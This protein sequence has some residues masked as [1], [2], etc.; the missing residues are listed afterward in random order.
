MALNSPV[1]RLALLQ[2]FPA[3]R[4][5]Q[6]DENRESRHHL[7]CQHP[8]GR[9]EPHGHRQRGQKH[10]PAARRFRCGPYV[11]CGVDRAVH[12]RSGEPAPMGLVDNASRVRGAIRTEPRLQRLA[13]A[14]LPALAIAGLGPF[15]VRDQCVDADSRLALNGRRVLGRRP[16]TLDPTIDLLRLD[17]DSAGQL[18]LRGRLDLLDRGLD[19]GHAI[20]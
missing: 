11:G 7:D 8:F 1:F 17:L 15:G 5:G 18:S 16:S 20:I 2:P 14:D 19:G 3:P 4:G 6:V 13:L 9:G 12:A 10:Q